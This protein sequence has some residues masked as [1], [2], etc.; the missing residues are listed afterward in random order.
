M[1][2]STVSSPISSA[3]G[4]MG[5]SLRDLNLICQALSDD[6]PWLT[7]ASVVDKPWLL[8]AAPKKVSIGIIWWDE[9]VMPHPPVQRALKLAV[10]K[11]RAAGHEGL[12][13]AVICEC[14]SSDVK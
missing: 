3:M 11:L 5:R 8:V 13:S 4:P 2:T 1:N 12:S 7:D 14:I 6:Q 10:Q 9:I